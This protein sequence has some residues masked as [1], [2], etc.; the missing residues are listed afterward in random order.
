[1]IVASYWL[2]RSHGMDSMDFMDFMDE[3]DARA[4]SWG[5]T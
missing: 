2:H 5:P 4:L 3:M 1:M